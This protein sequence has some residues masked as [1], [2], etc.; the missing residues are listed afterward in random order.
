MTLHHCLT[1][2]TRLLTSRQLAQFAMVKLVR[3]PRPR[4]AV[5]EETAKAIWRELNGFCS[6]DCESVRALLQ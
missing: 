1:C 5:V 3:D 2:D 4:E 6:D